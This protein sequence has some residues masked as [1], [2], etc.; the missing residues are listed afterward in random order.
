M[1]YLP[2]T[3]IQYT[4]L[5]GFKYESYFLWL[6]ILYLYNPCELLLQN[7]ICFKSALLL[8]AETA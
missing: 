4:V 5:A 8:F 3:F 6:L 7:T 1:D 2:Y